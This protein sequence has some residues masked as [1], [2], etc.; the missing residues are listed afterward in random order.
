MRVA[1]GPY[2]DLMNLAQKSLTHNEIS[3]KV[4]SIFNEC[5]LRGI[6]PFN[7]GSPRVIKSLKEGSPN[8][9]CSGQILT[10]IHIM[11]RVLPCQ[12][13]PQRKMNSTC[14]QAHYG[15]KEKASGLAPEPTLVPSNL[16]GSTIIRS[17]SGTT[18]VRVIHLDAEL[19]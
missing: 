18:L 15:P 13:C 17:L 4:I 19:G 14:Q 7:E 16:H 5:S 3:P 9:Y 11:A 2:L 8:G 1:Q 12:E 6:N 10:L